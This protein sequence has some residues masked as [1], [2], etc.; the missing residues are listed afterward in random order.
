MMSRGAGWFKPQKAPKK[1]QKDI[2]YKQKDY[3]KFNL[4]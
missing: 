4:N 2:E 3:S 1:C